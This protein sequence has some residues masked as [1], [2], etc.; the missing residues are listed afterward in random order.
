MVLVSIS[1][2]LE[3]VRL[4]VVRVFDLADVARVFDVPLAPVE[5]LE[6]S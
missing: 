5:L 4:L 3:D 1:I 2:P 6:A